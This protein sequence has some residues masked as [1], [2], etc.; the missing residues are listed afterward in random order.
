MGTRAAG[1]LA[2]TQDDDVD[3]NGAS[4]RASIYMTIRA[5]LS[6]GE[7]S[8]PLIVRGNNGGEGK[9]GVQVWGWDGSGG[10]DRGLG[11]EEVGRMSVGR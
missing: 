10:W 4:A 3:K 7:R 6:R 1:L 9:G 2:K 11:G 5:G 8:S